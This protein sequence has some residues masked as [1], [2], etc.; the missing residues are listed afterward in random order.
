MTAEATLYYGKQKIL[1]VEDDA[2]EGYKRVELELDPPV[3]NK[4]GSKDVAEKISVPEWELTAL[5][6]EEPVDLT[7]QRN[8]RAF[9]V[10][11]KMLELFLELDVRAEEVPYYLSRVVS[12]LNI[13]E[14]TAMLKLYGIS[15]KDD[16][17]LSHMDEV[18]QE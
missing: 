7:D 17:R 2:K 11:K 15:S 8:R 1:S 9:H 14:E 10:V 18:I 3:E 6:N 13:N 4:D 12:S 16:L 5:T